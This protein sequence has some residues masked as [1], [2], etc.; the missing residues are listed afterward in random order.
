MSELGWS[1]QWLAE[2]EKE[3]SGNAKE[4]LPVAPEIC[5]AYARFGEMEALGRWLERLT[6]PSDPGALDP[7]HAQFAKWQ[8]GQGNTL[9]A[10]NHIAAINSPSVSD[11]LYAAL[12]LY[13][14]KDQPIKSGEVLLMIESSRIR[15]ET[16]IKLASDEGFAKSPENIHRLIAA[17]GDSASSLAA[18]LEA[19]GD[20]ADSALIKELTADLKLPDEDFKALRI[21]R[22]ETMLKE[23][24]TS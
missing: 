12:S 19:L 21:A 11:P 18:I 3:R 22:L 5:L 4:L 9:E 15:R 6:D 7:L 8:L 23:A 14:L 16:G 17:V 1:L 10:L 20:R 2:L 13:W 24:K